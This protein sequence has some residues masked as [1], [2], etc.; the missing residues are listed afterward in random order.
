MKKMN[1][2]Q[3]ENLQGGMSKKAQCGIGMGIAFVFGTGSLIAAS[4]GT[5][6]GISW[7]I[8]ANFAGWVGA[9][10]GC[11]DTDKNEIAVDSYEMIRVE[12]VF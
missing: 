9:A 8:G 12:P 7:A 4:G 11:M 6:A 10:I 3:M 5:L 2:E 1:F